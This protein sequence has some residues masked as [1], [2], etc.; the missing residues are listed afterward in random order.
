MVSAQIVF[1][2]TVVAEALDP[3]LDPDRGIGVFPGRLRAGMLDALVAGRVGPTLYG[4]GRPVIAATKTWLGP[5][6]VI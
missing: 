1:E 6:S 4:V 3:L 5:A 2:Q